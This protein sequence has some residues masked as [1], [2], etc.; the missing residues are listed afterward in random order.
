MTIHHQANQCYNRKYND[1]EQFERLGVFRNW[2]CQNGY[3][4]EE[5]LIALKQARAN[6]NG[7]PK[8]VEVKPEITP[9]VVPEVEI[10]HD[11]RRAPP[12]MIDTGVSASGTRLRSKDST[13]KSILDMADEKRKG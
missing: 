7:T 5:I 9:E 11:S 10:K 2:C 8:Q 4:K 6:L 3:S 13:R 12:P 1:I